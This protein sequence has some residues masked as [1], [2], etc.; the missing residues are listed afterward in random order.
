MLPLMKTLIITLQIVLVSLHGFSQVDEALKKMQLY[1]GSVYVTYGHRITEIF[2]E[3]TYL[4]GVGIFPK[5]NIA[6]LNYN[7]LIV[8]MQDT[9]KNEAWDQQHYLESRNYI[10][11]NATGGR[12]I[13]YV[14]RFDQFLTNNKFFFIIIRDKNEKKLFE[15][16][17]PRRP[18][19]LVT[20]DIFSNWAYIDIDVELPDEFYVYVNHKMTDYLSDTKFLLERNAAPLYRSKGE[21]LNKDDAN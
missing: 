15:Y 8:L 11:D 4:M 14:E 2:S 20:T 9:A 18:A 16:Y 5:T 6:Y 12:I 10:K 13:L 21:S 1:E 7:Q 3:L 19:D 17:L